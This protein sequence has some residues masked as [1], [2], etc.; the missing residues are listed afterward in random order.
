MITSGVVTVSGS[1]ADKSSRLVAPNEPIEVLSVPRFV[2]RGGEKIEGAL[3][4]LGVQVAGRSVM[5]A[6]ASTGGFVDCLLQ[7][8]ARRVFAIDVG[9]NQMHERIKS[10]PRVVSIEGVNV[11]EIDASDLPFPCSLVV[12]DLSFIS[13]LKVVDNLVSC[14]SPEDG[15]PVPQLLLLVKPQFEVG[16]VEAS[17]GR[18]VIT[19]PDLHRSAVNGVVAALGACGGETVGTVESPIK[20]ADGNTEFFVLA[21]IRTKSLGCGS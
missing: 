4:A 11:R 7:S 20:G 6:G 19:D 5:D 18:G 9:R 1:I 16:R 3:S 17:R 21:S 12:A 2:S 8:G 14:V 13:L 15:F 10:D